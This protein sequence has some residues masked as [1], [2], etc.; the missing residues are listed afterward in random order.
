MMPEGVEHYPG[1]A[2]YGKPFGVTDS[3]MP[4]GVE[5]FD[6]ATSAPIVVT[7]TDSMMPEGVEHSKKLTTIEKAYRRDRF[8]DAGRR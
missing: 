3:M 1:S 6:V 8:H 7:V 4:E 2:D 5:H